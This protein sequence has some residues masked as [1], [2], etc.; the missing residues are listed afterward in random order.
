MKV[1][2][3]HFNCFVIMGFGIVEFL[4]ALFYF[5]ITT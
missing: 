3:K 5:H 1:V 4:Q 2:A